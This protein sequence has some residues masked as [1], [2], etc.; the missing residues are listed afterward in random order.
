MVDINFPDSP[1][2]GDKYIVSGKSWIW[3]GSVWDI[4]GAISVGPQGPTGPAS[5]VPGPTGP[6]GSIGATGPTGA[7]GANGQDGSGITILGTVANVGA[8][9]STGNNPGDSYVISGVL[10]AWDGTQWVNVGQVQGPTGPTGPTGQRGADSTVVGPSGPTG[11]TGATGEDGIGYDGITIAIESFVGDTLVGELNKVGALVNG[12]TVRIISNSDPLVYADGTI[13]S[14]TGT[15]V[16]I[17]I[18]FNETGGTLAALVNPKVTLSARQGPTGATGAAGPTGP[19]GATGAA[20]TIPGPTG[21]T[22]ERGEQG[23]T[24]STGPTGSQGA[25][26]DPG[27]VAASLPISYDDETQVVSMS[28][29]FVY[30]T[31]GATYRKLYVGLQPTG[32]AGTIQVG[33]VWIQV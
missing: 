2:V 5:T 8:L 22:G 16:S 1:D 9:P 17:S 25:T 7:T 29:G 11:P 13:F 19:T 14:L 23:L 26:G 31:T 4:F 12:S 15:D 24:G 10:Y 20:S 28:S 33:D 30:Y 27:V 18:F 3:N 6:T 21:P 32:P